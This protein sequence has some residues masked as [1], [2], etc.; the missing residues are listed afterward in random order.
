MKYVCDG[1]GG[2]TWFRIETEAEAEAES[3][4]MAHAVA[5]HF[6][7]ARDAAA[8]AYKPATTVYIEQ[9]IG[10]AAHLQRT[11]PLFLT[12]RQNDGTALVTAMLPP[13]DENENEGEGFFR[14]I[15]VGAENADPYVAHQGAIESL[16]RHFGLALARADCFPYVN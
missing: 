15:I 9:N 1:P 8:A 16:G 10:L 6:R 5:K 12:L 11:M 14:K 2:T 3:G 7:R 4:L 13:E